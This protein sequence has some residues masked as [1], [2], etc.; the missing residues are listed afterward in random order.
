[1]YPREA[2]GTEGWRADGGIDKHDSKLG[3]WLL[4][5]GMD[6]VVFIMVAIGMAG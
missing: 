2:D 3:D 1:L 6:L 5:G 4:T